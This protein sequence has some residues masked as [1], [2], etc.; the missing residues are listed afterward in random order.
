MDSII[1]PAIITGFIVF[2][3]I[4]RVDVFAAFA[5]GAEEGLKIAVKVLPYIIAM[6]LAITVF[7][8]SGGL[9]LLSSLLRPVFNLAGIPVEIVP[10]S[11]LRPFSGGGAVGLLAEIYQTYGPDSFIGRVA[12]VMMGS[13]ETIFYTLALY[14]GSV[15]IKKSRHTLSV[16]LA[17]H[18]VCIILSVWVVRWLMGG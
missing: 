18:V 2:G 8:E 13:T 16:A 17:A 11:V 4:K 5:E 15:G 14:F 1:I 6:M 3:M 7:R 10:I 9:D 12:S